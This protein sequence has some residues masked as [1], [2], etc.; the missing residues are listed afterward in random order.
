LATVLV[1]VP[2]KAYI[3]HNPDDLNTVIANSKNGVLA[4][5]V[6]AAKTKPGHLADMFSKLNPGDLKNV[7]TNTANGVFSFIVE[8]AQER[9]LVI[10]EEVIVTLDPRDLNAI[11]DSNIA[12]DFRFL[13]YVLPRLKADN[14]NSILTN[15]ENRVLDVF[16]KATQKGDFDVFACALSGLPEDLDPANLNRLLTTHGEVLDSLKKVLNI[17]FRD[18]LVLSLI[19]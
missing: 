18:Y 8:A 4:C 6:A 11:L 19:I 7:L 17:W 1:G 16:V 12:L 5:L 2:K 15:P 9:R 10:L 13:V 14:L 3:G